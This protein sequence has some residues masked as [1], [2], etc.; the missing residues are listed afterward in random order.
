[1]L[2]NTDTFLL[3]D[4]GNKNELVAALKKAGLTDKH[5]YAN[6]RLLF[7]N[8]TKLRATLEED[9]YPGDDNH[10]YTLY[11]ND[12]EIAAMNQKTAMYQFY[13]ILHVRDLSILPESLIG[14]VEAENISR[15]RP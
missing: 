2:T 11:Y 8:G 1:M 4:G 6:D 3:G 7:V 12:V 13:E 15:M 14:E 9:R 5:F 10:F